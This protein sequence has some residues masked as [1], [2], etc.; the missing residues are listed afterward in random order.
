MKEASA[1]Q[2]TEKYHTYNRQIY[3]C[4]VA[5]KYQNN[6][7][8]EFMKKGKILFVLLLSVLMLAGCTSYLNMS[9]TF[10][11]ETGEKVKVT[12]DLLSGMKMTADGSSF[13]VKKGK[14][15][16][17]SGVFITPDMRGQYIS[18]VQASGYTILENSDDSF[19]WETGADTPDGK[20][21]YDRIKKIGTHLYVLAG[22]QAGWEASDKAMDALSFEIISDG[23]IDVSHVGEEGIQGVIPGLLGN[24]GENET[25]QGGE[26]PAADPQANAPE[27]AAPT[28]DAPQT[29]VT[30][31]SGTTPLQSAVRNADG[32]QTLSKKV[33]IDG[34][35]YDKTAVFSEPVKFGVPELN[36][37]DNI[38]FFTAFS[39]IDNEDAIIHH[40]LESKHSSSEY[41]TSVIAT[42]KDSS[43]YSVAEV[44]D[45]TREFINGNFVDY[46][47]IKYYDNNL[48]LLIEQYHSCVQMGDVVFAIDLQ[49]V[50]RDG[51][52]PDLSVDDI[53]EAWSLINFTDVPE[54]TEP[55][56]A[57]GQGS[58]S[59]ALISDEYTSMLRVG[60]ESGTMKKVDSGD[61][62]LS[63]QN[64]SV[65]VKHSYAF[66]SAYRDE[67]QDALACPI[68][69]SLDNYAYYCFQPGAQNCED[70]INKAPVMD[71]AALVFGFTPTDVS[72]TK[73]MTVGGKEVWYKH[74]RYENENNGQVVTRWY[75]CAMS[76]GEVFTVNFAD[77][78]NEVN[79]TMVQKAWECVGY[80]K[81]LEMEKPLPLYE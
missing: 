10:N 22:S 56:P 38:P 20:K 77:T 53:K 4:L 58:N 44:T 18:S 71:M 12:L 1:G 79:E 19:K 66:G 23:E 2:I 52:A 80:M 63:G 76:D 72:E 78:G 60:V 34:K 49:D 61:V 35:T 75:T 27:A 42:Y 45:T 57:Q 8:G 48:G 47:Y 43:N 81:K 28:T 14:E 73:K 37:K 33:I 3:S 68:S 55:V 25:E 54:G 16:V 31:A 70:Y 51:K 40:Y 64:T 29:D 46:R 32:T 74:A 15:D 62:V 24:N 6:L 21:E 39:V 7:K 69:D 9:Y 65:L 36:Y 5:A 30:A 50:C 11:I 26:T 41:L 59:G 13:T 17:L 67:L